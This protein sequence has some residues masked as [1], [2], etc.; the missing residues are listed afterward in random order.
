M[1]TVT[2][3]DIYQHYKRGEHYKVLHLATD[4]DTEEDIV[5]YQAQ[6]GEGRVFTRKRSVFCEKVVRDGNEMLRFSLVQK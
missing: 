4:S 1:N 6:Y 2:V 3:G 5:V